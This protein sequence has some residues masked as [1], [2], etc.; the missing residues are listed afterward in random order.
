MSGQS[1]SIKF[2][3]AGIALLVFVT[4]GT[5]FWSLPQSVIPAFHSVQAEWMPSDAYL[6]DRNGEV[7]HEQRVDFSARRKPWM[8]LSTFSPAL[9]KAI[10][11]AEDRRFHEH[12]GVDWRAMAAAAWETLGGRKRG[13]STITMQL[14]ALLDLRLARYGGGRSIRQK[15]GQ[16]TAAWTL[17]RRWNKDEI[18]EAYLNQLRFRGELEGVP[19]TALGLFGKEASGL[20]ETEA[21]LLAAVLPS[22]NAG[23]TRIARRACG[24]ARAAAFTVDCGELERRAEMALARVHRPPPTVTLVP[25]LARRLLKKHGE[26]VRTTLS[27]PVQRRVIEALEQQLR[28]LKARNVRDG[29]ALAVDN[30][31]GEVLAYV[32]SVGPASRAPQVDGVRAR[33]QAG[34]TLKPFLY[35]LALER[36][37]LTAASILDDSPLN[38][39]TRT[40]LYVPQN[41]DRNFKGRVSV[42]TALAASLNIPAIRTLIL[43]GLEPF[44]ERLWN[45]GYRGLTQDGEYYGYSLALG[46]AEVSLWEQVNAFR[47]LANGGLLSPLHWLAGD[48]PAES[49]PI[50][51]PRAAYIV[52][53]I[54]SDRSSRALGFGLDNPLTT[55]YWSAVKT[56]TSKNMRDNWCIGFSERYTVGVWV[57]NFE[58]DAMHEVSGVTGAAPAWLEIMNGLHA[59]LPSRPPAPPEG[60]VGRRIRY[61]DA[62]EPERQEWFVAG[63]EIAEV[64]APEAPTPRI[65]TPADGMIIA[66]DPDIP[67]RNQK[68]ILRARPARSGISFLLDG[69]SVGYAETPMKWPPEPGDHVL[70]LT[71]DRGRTLD[72]VKF[73]VRGMR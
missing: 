8:P 16:I 21:V 31:S 65:E 14:T 4:G 41:Y 47:T 67:A 73:Q 42:R 19:A 40:G 53:S 13:A 23:A 9:V 50:I 70:K 57:G 17:E 3:G 51:D 36:R 37:Y 52:G 60:V 6:L 45:L 1:S 71:D 11:A 22:P 7:I 62:L 2:W 49:R 5:V 28:G 29:A 27:A 24:I 18:L 33:R 46:S 26:K 43:V 66:L 34:S 68:I 63:T 56:G 38:L 20:D 64:M 35:A 48:A 32:G 30:R 44:H 59:D 12:G 58:G 10:L 61:A 25:H 54:L 69:K 15:L 39:E 72:S 55:R